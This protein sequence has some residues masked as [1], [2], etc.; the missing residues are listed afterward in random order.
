VHDSAPHAIDDPTNPAHCAR[1]APSHCAAAQTFAAL[2]RGHASRPPWGAPTTGEHV[3]SLPDTS[4][5]SHCPVQ[6][7][8][9]QYPSTQNPLAHSSFDVHAP[10]GSF[11][12]QA[13][14]TGSQYALAAQSASL[15]QEPWQTRLVPS[16]VPSAHGGLPGW[17]LAT[18]LH[19]PAG[20]AHVEHAPVQAV[21]QQSPPAQKP[22]WHSR[23]P[24]RKQSLPAV[25]LQ[26]AAFVFC[27]THVAADEQ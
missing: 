14:W 17:P 12:T 27:A 13:C 2:P 24:C 7:P 19:V 23:H 9:Q 4:H 11:A 16:H 10:L 3:P 15:A 6:A 21:S 5:A 20:D 8:L 18:G 26:A 25:V 22:L 1:T